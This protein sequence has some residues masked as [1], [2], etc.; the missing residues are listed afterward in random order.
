MPWAFQEKPHDL[1]MFLP[2]SYGLWF[3]DLWE[4]HPKD[5][6]WLPQVSGLVDS[7]FK[8]SLTWSTS[9]KGNSSLLRVFPLALGSVISP[10]SQRIHWLPRPLSCSLSPGPLPTSL[11]IQPQK[12]LVFPNSITVTVPWWSCWV[13]C[14]CSHLVG[15]SKTHRKIARLWMQE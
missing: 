12:N 2:V 11:L 3:W 5:I 6:S 14:S 1:Q 4:W 9:I 15:A 7:L 10:L 13:T 8:Y